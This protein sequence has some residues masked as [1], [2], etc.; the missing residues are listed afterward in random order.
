MTEEEFTDV[1]P[2]GEVIVH[3]SQPPMRF[4]YMINIGVQSGGEIWQGS[5]AMNGEWHWSLH[6]PEVMQPPTMYIDEEVM[7][8][9]TKALLNE[10]VR[11]RGDLA[12]D[13]LKDAITMRDRLLTIIEQTFFK[14]TIAPQDPNRP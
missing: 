7:A 14:P 11:F 9:L 10:P 13:H 1:R 6:K 4:G 5:I 8:A 12:L 2:H 3:I